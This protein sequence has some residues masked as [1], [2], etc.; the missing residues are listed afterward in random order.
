MLGSITVGKFRRPPNR[1]DDFIAVA[2]G[3]K[4]GTLVNPFG[5]SM[6]GRGKLKRLYWFFKQGFEASVL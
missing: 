3:R 2:D 4:A 6:G 5:I 1:R